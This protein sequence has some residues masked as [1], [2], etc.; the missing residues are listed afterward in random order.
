VKDEKFVSL[1]FFFLFFFFFFFLVLF[2]NTL[3]LRFVAHRSN[4]VE[5]HSEF[6]VENC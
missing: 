2:F 1:L 6:R 3:E 4:H 5:R